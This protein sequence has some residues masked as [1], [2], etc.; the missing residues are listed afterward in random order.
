MDSKQLENGGI[1]VILNLKLVKIDS[2]YCNYL[3]Q[4]DDRV[5]CNM[6]EKEL[7]PFVRT[8]FKVNQFKYFVPLSSSKQKY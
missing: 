3:K 2:K 4:F 7:R 6:N 8:L 5:M 1:L